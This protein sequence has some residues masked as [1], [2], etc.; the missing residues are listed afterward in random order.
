[1]AVVFEEKWD[2]GEHHRGG[3]VWNIGAGKVFYFQA[4]HETY[5][6]YKEAWPLKVVENAVV[7]V[8]CM[9][10]KSMGLGSSPTS[11]DGYI[12]HFC[13][14]ACYLTTGSHCCR[15]SPPGPLRVLLFFSWLIYV[16]S[17]L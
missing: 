12:E 9:P 2:K 8:R 4:G 5:G 15:P 14:V 10:A 6:V 1:M 7:E 17:L 13:E 16:K 3:M 11:P